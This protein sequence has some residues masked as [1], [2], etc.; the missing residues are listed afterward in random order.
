MELEPNQ[1]AAEE[2]V[3]P[4]VAAAERVLA[5]GYEAECEL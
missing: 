1:G 2:G 3:P 4:P 5:K